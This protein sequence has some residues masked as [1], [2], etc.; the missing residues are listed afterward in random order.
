MRTKTHDDDDTKHCIPCYLLLVVTFSYSWTLMSHYDYDD[1]TI[2]CYLLIAFVV[3]FNY[4]LML[5]SHDN[6]DDTIHCI[7]CC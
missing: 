3:E 7:A 6:D 5:M 4:S 1:D 2:A